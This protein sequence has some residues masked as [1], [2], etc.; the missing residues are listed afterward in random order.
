MKIIAL[1]DL[2][3][4]FSNEEVKEF[5]RYL[6]SPYFN[7]RYG[8][9]NLYDEIMKYYPLFLENIDEE[10]IYKK[11]TKSSTYNSKSFR[12]LIG[13]LTQHIY[14][15]FKLKNLEKKSLLGS[16][17][18]SDELRLRNL[19][20]RFLHQTKTFEKELLQSKLDMEQVYNL[21]LLNTNIVN[22]SRS[23]E[24]T[25]KINEL[26]KQTERLDKACSYLTMFYIIELS[27]QYLD[28]FSYMYNFGLNIKNNLPDSVINN[29]NIKEIISLIGKYHKQDFM[30]AIYNTM[31]NCYKNLGKEEYYEV[32][33]K[34]IEKHF[35]EISRDENYFHISNLI[36]YCILKSNL[37]KEPDYFQNELYKLYNIFLDNK[38]FKTNL[39]DYLSTDLFR[40]IWLCGFRLNKLDWVKN[41][42]EKYWKYLHPKD[43]KN[44]Y[45]FGNMTLNYKIGNFN[46]ALKYS[47]KIKYTSST[48]KYDVKFLKLQIFYEINDYEPALSILHNFKSM[49]SSDDMISQDKKAGYN[50]FIEYYKK[51]ITIKQE[52]NYPDAGFY[53]NLIKNTKEIVNKKWL[54]TQAGELEQKDLMA[55]YKKKKFLKYS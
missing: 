26:K 35:D 13:Y 55:N 21:Y 45:L 37:N 31:F 40:A 15:Y 49:I 7:K 16:N 27:C 39:S 53:K 2:L 43:A 14:N 46:E 47:G 30:V 17:F 42:I 25:T 9:V 8:L 28:F 10:D 41:V 4:T 36:N 24:K 51:L 20:S 33:K 50:N 48:F 29:I 32:Y 12:A 11:I 34:L 18:L 3:Q 5:R 1:F 22:F 44:M 38:L 23:N 6:I 19:S 52:G 54:I